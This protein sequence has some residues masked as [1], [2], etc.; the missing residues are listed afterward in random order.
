MIPVKIVP[1][2]GGGDKKERSGGSTLKYY[3]FDML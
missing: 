1:G 2:I 3:I